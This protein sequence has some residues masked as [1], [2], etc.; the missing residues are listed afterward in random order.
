MKI[1]W[2]KS[3]FLHPANRGGQIRTLEML[4]CLHRRHE[5]HYVAFDDGKN[6]E[7]LDR[8]SE[9][10]SRPYP[11]PH[12]VPPHRS[13]R[14]MGQLCQGL[15][16][17]VPVAVERYT[18]ARMRRCIKELLAQQKFDTLV[19]DFLFPAPNIPDMSRSVLFQ[20]NVES[21][22]WRRHVEHANNPVKK[23]YFKLQARRMHAFER[24][25]CRCAGHIVAVSEADREAMHRL[26][27]AEREGVTPIDTGVDITYFKAPCSAEV[28]KNSVVADL[29]F[30]GSMD[31]LPNVDAAQFFVAEV[32]PLI[33]KERPDCRLIIA[34]RRPTS[35]VEEL[36]QRDSGIVVTGTVPDVRPYLWG[37]SVSIV[38][39]R[40]GGGTRLKIFE[41][42]AAKVPVVSTSIGAEGL[43]L[44]DGKD[45]AI[46][47]SSELFARCCLDLLADAD[48]RRHRAKQAWELVSS[49]FSW[50]AVSRE[51]ESALQAGPRPN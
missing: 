30:T 38:P 43:P 20:H 17:S 37:S 13:L 12:S 23:A 42:M 41:A 34:G 4:K 29:I 27:G 35:A 50:E 21:I 6:P 46:A 15:V 32:L 7:G 22:I 8:S 51:F 11:V 3:D 39:L 33:R 24:A 9:Y 1:L 47:D 36:A 14:F 10:C 25:I 2:V 40:I 45:I 48:L 5:I 16:S 26:F 31:W 28:K 49:Q 44:K 18:S 19:C